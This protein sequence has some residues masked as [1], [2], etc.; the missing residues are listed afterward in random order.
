AGQ[1]ERLDVVVVAR[2]GGQ[3]A[4]G[5]RDRRG[6]RGRVGRQ[7]HQQRER[8]LVGAAEDL[9]AVLVVGVVGPAQGDGTGGD[10]GRVA[11]GR[12]RRPAAPPG[13]SR[14]CTRSPPPGGR[15]A[16]PAG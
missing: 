11:V 1:V 13:W 2:A 9:E 14:P 10:G 6:G 3:A 16:C 5:V 4:V 7:R 8:A 12:G 15:S